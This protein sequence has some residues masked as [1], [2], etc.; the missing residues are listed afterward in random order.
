VG[1]QSGPV[2]KFLAF[3]LGV[4]AL[5]AGLFLSVFV[6]AGLLVVGGVA[7]VWIWW[8]TRGL[9]KQLKESLKTAEEHIAAARTQEQRRAGE[10]T[11][12]DGDYI[13]P[14]DDQPRAR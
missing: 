3:T 2:A 6:F 5:A 12:I 4:A 9:R 11:I 10:P 13:R 8:R 14:K 1:S 7:G